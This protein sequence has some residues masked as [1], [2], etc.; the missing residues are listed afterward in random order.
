MPS[1]FDTPRVAA[2]S[3]HMVDA[4]GSPTPRF[5]Q[6]KVEADRKGH[7][8]STSQ[9]QLR[10]GFSSGARGSDLFFLEE[11]GKMGGRASVPVFFRSKN[12]NRLPWGTGGMIAS[13]KRWLEVI[14]LSSEAPPKE[15]N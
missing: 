4:P 9:A 2:F 14:E 10:Y 5:P 13:T 15:N 7:C 11:L 6:E 8:G 1:I 3:G 12:L